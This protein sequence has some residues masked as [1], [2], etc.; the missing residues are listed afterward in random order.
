MGIAAGPMSQTIHDSLSKLTDGDIRAIAAYLK[1]TPA[2]SHGTDTKVSGFTGNDPI[3][4]SAYLNNCASCHQLDGKGIAGSVPPLAGAVSVRAGGPQDVIRV[5]LGGLQAR[6]SYAPMPAMGASM[7]DQDVADVTNYI[8][9]SWGNV[10]KPDAGPGM[11]GDLRKGSVTAMNIGPDHRCP[12]LSEA[13]AAFADPKIGI[14]DALKSLTPATMLQTIGTILPK[15][16]AAAPQASQAELVNGLTEA[17]CPVVVAD[18]AVPD[19]L[20]VPQLD[21]FS[22][23]VYSEV[24][25]AGKE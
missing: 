8:R 20:K 15:A 7:T 23:R 21:Q 16:K 13:G 4:R 11:V 12:A 19:A 5:V 9:Q 24:R 2:V 10:A 6:G 18:P 22:D 14:E 25:T 17:Y 3:G 1:S